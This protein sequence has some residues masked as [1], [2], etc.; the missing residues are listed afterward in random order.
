MIELEGNDVYASVAKAAS[1]QVTGF[2]AA[3]DGRI[4]VAT[5]NPGK[6]F[7]LGPGY[8]IERQ[9]RVRHVRRQDFFALGP[10]D[11]VG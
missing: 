9:L 4:F 11:M 8:A 7:T 2:V 5:A 6:I 1:A 10:A 3:S